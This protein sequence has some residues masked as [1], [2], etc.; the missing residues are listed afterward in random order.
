[1]KWLLYS[2]KVGFLVV[3]FAGAVA[4][5]PPAMAQ[6]QAPADW[7]NVC[8]GDEI[9]GGE[10]VATI[11]GLQCLVANLFGVAITGLGFVGFVM[12]IY[13]AYRYMLSGGQSKGIEQGRNTITWAVIGLILGLSAVFILRILA[14]FTGVDTILE[15]VIPS[16]TT[17]FT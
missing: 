6:A 13:G 2:L 15:F 5:H 17:D 12:M 3:L 16:D 14:S 1:M 8:V 9:E 11:Q 4:T 10:D 7:G